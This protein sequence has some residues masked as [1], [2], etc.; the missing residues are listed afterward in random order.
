MYIMWDHIAKKHVFHYDCIVTVFCVNSS[1]SLT[2]FSTSVLSLTQNWN[3]TARLTVYDSPSPTSPASREPA[4]GTV[5]KTTAA[6]NRLLTKSIR[7]PNHLLVT[8]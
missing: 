5:E 3:M 2:L 4:R 7:I 8:R 6:R 1:F